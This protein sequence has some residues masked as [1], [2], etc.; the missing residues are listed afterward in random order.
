MDVAMYFPGTQ[1]VQDRFS[2]GHVVP[3]VDSQ[4]DFCVIR[5]NLTNSNVYVAFERFI[6]TGDPN[7]ISFIPNLYLMFSMGLYTLSNNGTSFNPQHHFFRIALQTTVNLLNCT[8]SK[9]KNSL[10][11]KIK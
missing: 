3:S 7:D 8:S 5:T 1:I 2:R 6:T 10:F 4:Q 11:R 9:R